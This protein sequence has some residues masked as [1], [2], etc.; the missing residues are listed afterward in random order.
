VLDHPDGP[1]RAPRRRPTLERK[2][3]VAQLE[4]D[5]YAIFDHADPDRAGPWIDHEPEDP[6]AAYLVDLYE[7]PEQALAAL[8]LRAERVATE[9]YPSRSKARLQPIVDEIANQ[10][11]VRR[12]ATREGVQ[13]R[14][15]RFCDC[16]ELPDALSQIRTGERSERAW[17]EILRQRANHDV[18]G[19]L[20]PGP[21]PAGSLFIFITADGLDISAPL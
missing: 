11:T 19:A 10:L 14:D 20:L 4:V 9:I 21:T 7:T 6:N 17:C 3:R 1:D 18:D 12:V 15:Y 16:D 5:D 13:G 2:P 8:R